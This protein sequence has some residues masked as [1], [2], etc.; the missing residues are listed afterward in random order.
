VCE[1]SASA[2]G[3]RGLRTRLSD[4]RV[5]WNADKRRSTEADRAK[6]RAAATHVL[7]LIAKVVEHLFREVSAELAW[8]QIEE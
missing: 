5:P 8:K 6:T 7:S 2:L 3:L 4:L 1:G